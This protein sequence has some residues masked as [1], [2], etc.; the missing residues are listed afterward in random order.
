MGPSAKQVYVF[1]G[2]NRLEKG[3][4]L[5]RLRDE[6]H[7]LDARRF[8]AAERS[9]AWDE[10]FQ[11]LRTFPPTDQPQLFILRHAEKCPARFQEGLLS[12]LQ[13]LPRQNV[14]VLEIEDSS[15]GGT[16]LESLES[17]AEVRLFQPLKREQLPT[18][19]TSRAQV[20][21]KRILREACLEL[22]ERG[23]ED[24]FFLER[25]IEQLAL[26]A[27]EREL[28]TVNDVRLLIQPVLFRSG[29]ELARAVGQRQ[30]K[31]ALRLLS[32]LS[33]HE[34][35]PAIVG[36]VAWHLRRLRQA[37]TLLQEGCSREE[38]SRRIGL[39]WEEREP[40]LKTASSVPEQEID[41]ALQKLLQLDVGTK[42]GLSEGAEALEIFILSLT[43]EGGELSGEA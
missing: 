17:R 43:Q 24:L 41:H 5:Q 28:L 25:A 13:K 37:Q 39:R 29:F 42:S 30:V 32:Q 33:P 9:P 18:W 12:T 34:T 15:L 14:V 21:G 4:A 7:V 22:L 40:F 10:F 6:L 23:G 31:E 16:F 19:I 8:D 3:Q 2:R 38:L 35:L 27:R 26:Y 11:S 36:S 20:R 1:A